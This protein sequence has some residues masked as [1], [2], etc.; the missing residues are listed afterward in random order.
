MADGPERTAQERE[1]ARRERERRRVGG[2]FNEPEEEPAAPAGQEPLVDWADPV[3]YPATEDAPGHDELSD[4]VAG[5]ADDDEEY[6]GHYGYDEDGEH[7]DDLAAAEVPSGTR[8]VS[9]L[10]SRARSGPV[11]RPSRPARRRRPPPAAGRK[12]HSWIGRV[13]SLVFLIVV[14]ALIWFLIQLF[15]P[16][17]T[18]PHGRVTVVVPAHSSTRQIGDLLARDGVVSSGLFFELRATIDGE[19]GSLRS[20]TYHFQ[21]GMSYS[22]VLAAL[23]KVPPAAKTSQL[24]ISEGHTRQY[25]SRLL[26]QQGIKGSYVAATRSSPLLDPRSYGAP[27]HVPSLE[28]FLFPDTFTLIDP[29]KIS[30]LVSDQLRDF[31]QRFATVNLSYA[32]SKHLTPYE[33]VKIASLIEAEA[34]NQSSR[35]LISS[36]IYNRLAAGMMLQL[37]S[38]TRYATGNV[39]GPL[40]VSQLHSP[41]PYNTRAHLGLPPTPIDS[42]GL[43]SLQAA[44]HPANSPY[45]YFFAKPCSNQS[46]FATSYTQFLDLLARD[47]RTHC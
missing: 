37:D 35:P 44:A 11:A 6:A 34:A 4:P 15:Q 24:T 5:D 43:A 33:V 13:V 25:V 10:H 12:G 23:T 42:P 27:A 3:H 18:S 45:L 21:L 36:V 22:A 8:R 7:G 17:G 26:H 2:V 20:G 28:G 9:R 19:R 32:R 38:T 14:A 16:L 40:T 46:V 41:S 39:T 31:K 1:A 29:I 47:R 30:A